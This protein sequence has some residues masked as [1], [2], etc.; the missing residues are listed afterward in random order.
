MSSD[1]VDAKE[2]EALEGAS[3]EIDSQLNGDED[4]I[5]LS[6]LFRIISHRTLIR[7]GVLMLK[8]VKCGI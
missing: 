4:Q 8:Y 3:C 5:E 2:K 7:S 6:G 1:Y